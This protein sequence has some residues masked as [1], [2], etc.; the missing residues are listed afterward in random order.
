MRLELP[1]T[2]LIRRKPDNGLREI[3]QRS[4]PEV[5]LE[6]LA[7]VAVGVALGVAGVLVTALF[8]KLLKHDH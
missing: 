6:G 3:E 7:F 5:N 4:W 8:A 2:R 1:S